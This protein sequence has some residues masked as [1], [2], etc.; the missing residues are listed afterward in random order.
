MLAGVFSALDCPY[1][2]HPHA[3]ARA[4]YKPVQHLVAER[5]GLVMPATLVTNNHAAARDFAE[6]VDG[7]LVCKPLSSLV[8]GDEPGNPL[9]TYTTPIEVADIEPE[10]FA[11]T[12][13]CLQAW[14]AKSW[15]ARI[16]MVGHRPYGVAIHA[17][18]PAAR[19]DWRADYA[20][21]R[22]S[23]IE[24]PAEVTT[25]MCHYLDALGLSFG[26]FDF[27][28]DGD[29][30]WWCFECNPAGQWLWL[31]H[32]ADVRISATLAELLTEGTQE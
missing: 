16:T 18:S 8:L 28:I 19:I 9:I 4:E 27:A 30:A 3:I 20:A 2:N 10:A 32:Q 29:G 21:L 23:L 1:V 7:P 6:T 14:V 12:A 17:D 11:V 31:E 24:P 25:A 13:H 26:A 5:A 22:Y 15:E